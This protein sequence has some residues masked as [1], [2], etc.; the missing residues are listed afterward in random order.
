MINA[1]RNDFNLMNPTH[2]ET[3][4]GDSME[5]YQFAEHAYVLHMVNAVPGNQYTYTSVDIVNWEKVNSFSGKERFSI[6][7]SD[8]IFSI[9]RCIDV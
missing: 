9:R 5:N 2:T 4:C 1:K 3:Q 6:E 7:S 8:P